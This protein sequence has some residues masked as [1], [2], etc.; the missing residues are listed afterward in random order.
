[1]MMKDFEHACD[2]VN[3]LRSAREWCSTC[4]GRLDTAVDD[5]ETGICQR[6]ASK[7]DPFSEKLED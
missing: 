1:M 2:R 6:C 3:V 4:G 7:R 5:T